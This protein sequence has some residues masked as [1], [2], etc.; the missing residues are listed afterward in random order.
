MKVFKTSVVTQKT[1]VRQGIVIIAR[2]GTLRATFVRLQIAQRRN[3]FERGVNTVRWARLRH[4]H[5]AVSFSRLSLFRAARCLAC[6][7]EEGRGSGRRDARSPPR[8][9]VAF[10][11]ARPTDCE[12][13]L[14]R[15]CRGPAAAEHRAPSSSGAATSP[16]NNSKRTD[17][18]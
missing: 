16:S 18:I 15:R 10:R 3:F 12:E 4:C 6:T 7:R 17:V 5:S 8:A 1:V 13:R 14:H 11:V 2:H 9:D